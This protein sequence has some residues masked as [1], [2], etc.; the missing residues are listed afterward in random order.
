MAGETNLTSQLQ[1]AFRTMTGTQ[2]GMLLAIA[3]TVFIALAGIIVWAGQESMGTLFSNLPPADANRIVEDLR[4]QSIKYDLS[5]D[6][7]SI[8]V[9]ENRVGELRLKYAADGL[10]H[11]E[12]IGFEKLE[13]PSLTTTDFT[14]KVMY[15]R[16]METHLAKTLKEGLSSLVADATVHITPSNDSPF[17]TEKED[18]KASVLLKL[19][20]SRLLPD[21]NTRAIV[22][23]MAASVEG[24]KPDNVVV[25][26]QY[27]R[28]LSK[29]GRDA[30]VG[31][32]DDQKK[33]QREEEEHL[34][35]RVVELLEPVVGAGKVRAT[36]NVVLDFDKVKKNEETFDPQG[37]V[38]R[39]VQQKDEKIT[40]RDGTA[41]VPGTPT[42]VAPANAAA[43]GGGNSETTERKES[44]TNFE[45]SKTVKATEVA[46]GSIKRL[47]V[48][49]VVDHATAWDTSGKEPVAKQNPRSAEE[50][51]K[52]R[53]QVAAAVGVQAQRGDQLTLENMAF[54]STVN[55]KEEAAAKKQ[56]WI[57]QA[58]KLAPIVGW[59][60]FG[61]VLFF[62]VVMP[63]LKKLSAALNRPAPIRVQGA[64]GEE[65]GT[66]GGQ[67]RATPVKSMSELQAEIEAELNAE[68]ASSAPEAQR[69]QLIKKRIQETATGDPETAAQLVR[70]WM[71][72]DGR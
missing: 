2:K 67:R 10:P 49:V 21:D 52:L 11:G 48:A 13:S 45:I 63:M 60:I 43:T 69:R 62:M 19:K 64:E 36:A 55:P 8:S 66:G 20:G 17:V 3:A 41:G 68:G 5:K 14:Q 38:E 27:S 33:I 56:F 50:L 30:L 1:N 31:A 37:Q 40:K 65:G 39:S 47:S 34:V 59:A 24:L 16:A 35:R 53:D 71:V 70:S 9:P 72:E 29:G 61:A 54:A 32:S 58:M 51:K 28:I 12:G 18:A 42:N 4:K 15:R 22:N 23:L 6:Q 25:V 44:T 7:R 26:D 46:P 57:D